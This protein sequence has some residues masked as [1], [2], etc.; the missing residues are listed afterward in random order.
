[1]EILHAFG[2]EWKL[3]VIQALNFAV[4]LFVLHRY[5]YKPVMAMLEKREQTIREGIEAAEGAMKEKERTEEARTQILLEA[6]EEGGKIVEDL[7]KQGIEAE[8]KM[9]RE[10]QEKSAATLAEAKSKAEEERDYILRES[11]KEVARMATLAAE[12]IL[13][14]SEVKA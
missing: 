6:R 10:A 7:H 5:A 4:V 11:E 14:G 1:M 9:L 13:R 2:I 3:I 12:K 8:R